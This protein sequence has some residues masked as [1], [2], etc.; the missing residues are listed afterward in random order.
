MMQQGRSRRLG[1]VLLAALCLASGPGCLCFVHSLDAPPKEQVVASEK[2][3]APCRNHVHVFLLQGLDP[4]DLANINGLTEY[5]HQLGYLKTHCGQF[6]HQ[7][8]FRKEIRRIHKDEPE[9]RFV[10]I[11]FSLG[12]LM[13]SE[14]ANAVKE[15]GIAIDSLIYLG[16]FILDNTPKTQPQNAGYIANILTAGHL[17]KGPQMDRAENIRCRNVWHFGLPTHL[18]TRTL[19]ARQLA[20]AAARVPYADKVPPLPPEL[21]EE[22]PRP[23]RLTSDQL[24][25]MSMKLP[26]EWAFLDSR[27]AVGEAPPPPLAQPPKKPTAQRVPF[28]I[29]P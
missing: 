18:E 27:S 21:E 7:W 20:V 19:L 8:S 23:R 17:I 22:I 12:S 25:Q 2:I 28:A 26:S 1:A 15:D 6:F 10:V 14:L 11:G 29:I 3:P 24:R 13:A 16:G 5:L 4:L 9:A